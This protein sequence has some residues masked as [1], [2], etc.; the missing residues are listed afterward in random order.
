MD[1]FMQNDLVIL[2]QNDL[3]CTLLTTIKTLG[4][5]NIALLLWEAKRVFFLK[6][7][8]KFFFS[9]P[10]QKQ[11]TQLTLVLMC[12]ILALNYS[13]STWLTAS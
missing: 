9:F 2:C 12:L 10:V 6:R 5:A 7:K 4:T 1:Y 11:L 3:V 8:A 13:R